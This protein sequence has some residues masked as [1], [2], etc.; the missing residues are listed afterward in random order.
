MNYSKTYILDKAH[1]EECFSESV[2][3]PL[4]FNNFIKAIV[5]ALAG[6]GFLLFSEQ[7]AYV[8]WFLIGLGVVD[9]VSLYYR[10]PWWVLR[11]LMSRAA[12]N[13]LTVTVDEQGIKNKSH[14]VN[15][16][17]NWQDI[18]HVILTDKGLLIVH[19]QVKHYLSRG[20]LSEE[21]YNYI[22]QHTTQ[23]S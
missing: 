13:E 10:K 11:Q 7:D 20:V 16:G 1:F 22:L 5:L 21:A 6:L 14:Y 17:M 18:E 3:T 23:S 15:Q 4:T 19:Q 2:T 8:A 12:N 9:A